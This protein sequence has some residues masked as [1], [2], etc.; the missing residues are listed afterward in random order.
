MVFRIW[1][2]IE[3]R[4]NNL[5]ANFYEGFRIGL[6]II[7]LKFVVLI[8][9]SLFNFLSKFFLMFKFGISNYFGENINGFYIL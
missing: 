8:I 5:G 6:I 1:K 7:D 9:F 4:K 2:L 3:R